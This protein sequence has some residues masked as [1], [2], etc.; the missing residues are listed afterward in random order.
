MPQDTQLHHR[1]DSDHATRPV[2]RRSAGKGKPFRLSGHHKRS[3]N[4]MLS[5]LKVETVHALIDMAIAVRQVRSVR[6]ELSNIVEDV[7]SSDPLG[8]ALTSIRIAMANVV[9]GMTRDQ[10][11]ELVALMW[12][13]QHGG[14]FDEW[15]EKAIVEVDGPSSNTALYVTQKGKVDEY[16]NAGLEQLGLP[17]PHKATE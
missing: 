12:T 2:A 9:K 1:Y 6:P 8:V 4:M 15:A 11:I 14:S 3:G 17:T 10:K 7:I 16:L 5:E 13:G